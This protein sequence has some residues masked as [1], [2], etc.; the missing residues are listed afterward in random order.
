[1]AIKYLNATFRYQVSNLIFTSPLNNV[2]E[3]ISSP[4][5]LAKI[6]SAFVH[7]RVAQIVHTYVVSINSKCCE[8]CY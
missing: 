6:G 4:Y 3:N 1:M 7:H 8:D 5:V 2:F